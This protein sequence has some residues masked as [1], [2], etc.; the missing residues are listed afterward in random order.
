MASAA[1][2]PFNAHTRLLMVAPH[3]DDETLAAGILLQRVQAAG[4]AADVLLLTSGGNNPW[5]QRVLERRLRIDAAA[6]A[7][8]ATRRQREILAALRCLG[9]H[10][11]R[12]HALDWPDM[13]LLDR[14]LQAEGTAVATLRDWLLRLRPNL[15]VLPAL[16]DRHP[17]HGTAHVLLRL[18]L[19]GIAEPPIVWTY[20][21]HA[22]SVGQAR[23]DVGG[24]AAQ[25]E[26]K[27]VALAAHA[28]QTAL[29]GGRLRR[30]A[31]AAE[32]FDE[33]TPA[34]TNGI[35]PWRPPA[36]LQPLLWL[37]VVDARGAQ[38]WRW[39]QA[40]LRRG[41]EGG[42]RLVASPEGSGPRFARLGLRIP[43]PW[44]FDHWGWC[45][46]G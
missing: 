44:I 42:Y 23:I 36:L 7:R 37:S 26:T 16:S 22:A 38:G 11:E 27:L 31:V 3:P 2:T 25:R 6:Q 8:W 1:A 24:T 12:L 45:E 28:S 34:H 33:L 43:S 9:V 18:A 21:V 29:S 10:S 13:G 40:P 5:P 39:P 17:D 20:L 19:A 35:L 41:A 4:G 30:L 15:L 14:L 46:I 32:R